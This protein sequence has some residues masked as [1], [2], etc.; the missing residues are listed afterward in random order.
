M[1]ATLWPEVKYFRQSEFDSED[2]EGSGA[3]M[4]PRVVFMLDA[5]R[6]LMGRP[7]V[8]NSG[9][10]TPEHNKAEGGAPLSGHLTGEAVDVKT[11]GWTDRERC[12]FIIYAVKLGFTGIGI[13]K[14]FIHID[15]KPRRASWRYASGKTIPIKVGE[16]LKYV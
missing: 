7:F 9:F 6:G 14:T 8:V 15:T 12:D 1:H 4:K 16:E 2:R 5:L 13:G 11:R 3:N 10:R